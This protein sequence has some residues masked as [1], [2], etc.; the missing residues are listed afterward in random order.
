MRTK[1][2]LSAEGLV[3]L[4]REFSLGKGKFKR[5]RYNKLHMVDVGCCHPC[6]LHEMSPFRK[7]KTM[8]EIYT[9]VYY[10][11]RR[12]PTAQYIAAERLMNPV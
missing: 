7:S 4:R 3:A 8:L 6:P 10:C 2:G 1:Q 12:I 11:P 5:W 9:A